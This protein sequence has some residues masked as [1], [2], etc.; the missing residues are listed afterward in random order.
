MTNKKTILTIVIAVIIVLIV[1]GLA[2]FYLL[3][4]KQA[5]VTPTPKQEINALT[6]Y[7]WW[8]SPGESAALNALVNIFIKKYPDVAIMPTSVIGGAG[9]S[10]LGIIKPLVTAGQAPDSFQM[11]A[12]Y[13]G[14]P[15][16]KAG[17]LNPVDDIWAK[18]Q[19]A[20]VIPSVVQDM[21][22]FDGHYYS[23]PVDIHRVNIVWYNKKL[24][25]RNNIEPLSLA[26]WDAFFA[27]CDKLKTAGI[28]Y[29]ISLG[30]SWTASHAFEQIVASQ[31]IDFYQDWVNGKVLSADDPRLLSALGTFKKYLS[32][33]NPDYAKMTWN[34]AT[35]RVIAGESAFN[36]MG[37][38]A[39]QEF[40]L[41]GKKY[42]TDYGTIAVPGTESVYGLCIDTFQRPKNIAH[43]T[44]ADRWLDLVSSKEGQDTFNPLKGSISARTDAD[45]SQY[46]AYQQSAISDFWKAKYMFPSVVHGSGAPQSFK[47]KLGDIIAEFLANQDVT[48]TAM[49]MTNYSAVIN[50]EYTIAWSL[51]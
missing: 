38:W 30:E 22:K 19:L 36:I 24:L 32:Y 12:G 41:A 37:D 25:E 13:E 20:E 6:F 34:D 48:N 8:T 18:D 26:S 33:V 16:Y 31:G 10:M 2:A 40:K 7:D 46:D 14:M 17:L 39:N 51:K 45:I 9:Y 5:A 15:Y 3:P 27:A 28:S 35:G 49:A 23:V 11:H 44:N 21:N 42:G 43:P 47:I 1:G 50:D 4:K 29:P